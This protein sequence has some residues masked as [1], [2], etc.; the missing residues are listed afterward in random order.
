MKI[1]ENILYMDDG[2]TLL[3][4][5]ESGWRWTQ[6]GIKFCRK[7][8]QED[9][10]ISGLERTRRILAGSMGII[11]PYLEFTTE[12]GDDFEDGWLPTLDTALRI[13]EDNTV[14]FKFW[15]KP[16]NSRRTV[17]K[18]TAFG[19]NQKVQ[20]LTQEV[21]RR[22]GNTMEEVSKEDYTT[23]MDN[24]CQKLYNSGYKEEQIRR[25]MIAGIKGWRTKVNRCKA[26]GQK[27]RRSAKDSLGQRLR[28]KLIGK[29]TWFKKK[30]QR[31]ERTKKGGQRR[32]AK[33]SS[34]NT[35]PT[36]RSVLFVDQT[37]GGELASR[38]RELFTRL[39]PTLGFF[40]KVVER[41]GRRLQRLFPL[42]TCGK[43]QA[44]GGQRIALPATR[45]QIYSQIVPDSPSCTRMSVLDVYQEQSTRSR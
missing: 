41:P 14:Q 6:G 10:G 34:D 42:T 43:E 31:A 18:R 38:L 9:K 26:E 27:V 19:E 24:Y 3:P 7:W 8:E 20:I 2:R 35:T 13:S 15:E 30:G 32:G 29:T 28:T 21:I 1:W 22:M 44:V 37:L 23:I 40:V 45:G 11:E 5:F 17:D 36:P 33:S 4:P 16:T 39:E 12:T 25:I